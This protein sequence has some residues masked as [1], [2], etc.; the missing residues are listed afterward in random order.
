[1]AACLACGGRTP[2]GPTDPEPPDPT[3]P[4][5]TIPAPPPAG[6][7]VFVGAGDI[8]V[9]GSSGTEGTASLLDTIG[10]TVFTLGDNAYFSGTREDFQNCYHPTWGRHRGR[11]RPSPGN[12]DYAVPGAGPYFEYFGGNA[13]P[14]GLGYYSF[15][16]GEWLAVSLN[17]NVP[18]GAGSA[19]AAWLRQTL[20]ADSSRCTIAYWH[21]PLFS[22][23]QHGGSPGVRELWRILYEFNADVI[24]AG[25][26]HLYERM[27]PQDPDG[28][29]DPARG[30]RQFIAGTGGAPLYQFMGAT[31][32]TEVQISG[33]GVLK[34]TLGP[35]SYAWDFI[36]LSGAGDTG[37]ASCH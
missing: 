34:L 20:A 1:M 30:I 8:A 5:P 13:G 27:A 7:P 18:A 16:V 17:S 31:P 3:P 6:S 29:P 19:Q 2:T 22:S 23:G 28:A 24:L 26:E 10:G 37:F 12:H 14:A 9:C 4:G 11:T 33:F 25:H 32:N 21:H 36:P 15:R 35:E